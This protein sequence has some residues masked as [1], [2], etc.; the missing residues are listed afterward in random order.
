[1][2]LIFIVCVVFFSIVSRCQNNNVK[3]YLKLDSAK[4]DMEKLEIYKE[5]AGDGFINFYPLIAEYSYRLGYKKQGLKFLKKSLKTG[6]TLDLEFINTIP[7]RQL[8]KIKK[9]YNKYRSVFYRTYNEDLFNYVTYL[10]NTDQY[11]AKENF[12]G[13]RKEQHKIREKV[14]QKNLTNLRGYIIVKNKGILPQYNQIGNLTTA[15]TLMLIH[16]T[17]N[18]SIDGVNYR[19]FEPL[20][21]EE[22]LLRKTYSPY[23][24]IQ[25]IDNMV[26]VKECGDKQV[27][28]HYRDYKTKKIYPLMFPNK[29]DSLRASIGLSPLKDYAIKHGFGLPENYVEKNDFNT[30]KKR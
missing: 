10:V 5:M 12:Y 7:E 8:F 20:I 24:Y 18:D 9:R 6:S 11:L 14:F 22:V 17:S 28:G 21:K 27:Y 25:F 30:D 15:V 13:G 26:N 23:T 3:Q 16:H 1:M 29:V 19:F 2:K 4:K